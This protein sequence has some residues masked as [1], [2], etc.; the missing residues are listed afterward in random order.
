MRWWPPR[1]EPAAAQAPLRRVRGRGP[2]WARRAEAERDSVLT[3]CP[4]PLLAPDGY[5]GPRWLGGCGYAGDTLNS[6]ELGHGDPDGPYIRIGVSIDTW[7]LSD[8]EDEPRAGTVT[9]D[10]EGEPVVLERLAGSSSG[11]ESALGLWGERGLEISAS[12]H[13]IEGMRLSRVSD[14]SP[15]RAEPPRHD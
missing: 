5:D 11:E 2:R 13:P 9:V 15:Y 3:D 8:P 1:R 4:V 6:V 10:V 14:L 7:A 12:G